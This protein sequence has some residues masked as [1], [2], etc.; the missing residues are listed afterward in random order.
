MPEA[1]LLLLGAALVI[2][3]CA[4]ITWPAGLLAFGVLLI[5]AAVD[6]RR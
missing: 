6:L 1:V 3:G 4:L 5:L 2:L